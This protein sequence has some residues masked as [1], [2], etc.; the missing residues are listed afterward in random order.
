MLFINHTYNKD[1]YV[2]ER[3]EIWNILNNKLDFKGLAKKINFEIKR[4]S[5]L[6]IV[7]SPINFSGINNKSIIG[8]FK[9]GDSK[10]MI[11]NEWLNEMVERFTYLQWGLVEITLANKLYQETQ[12]NIQKYYFEINFQ[13]YSMYVISEIYSFWN[14]V[15]QY[16]NVLYMEEEEKDV[17]CGL[18]ESSE[19]KDNQNDFVQ[20]M[21]SEYM[22]AFNKDI[23]K[24][25]HHSTHRKRIEIT[26]LGPK[27]YTK[28]TKIMVELA[29]QYESIPAIALENKI[30]EVMN[31][32][33]KVMG[34][35]GDNLEM[36]IKNKG[37]SN[38]TI[39]RKN[40]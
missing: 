17:N 39:V 14:M 7:K 6:T 26:E 25:R 36:E 38:I 28:I 4:T 29:A 37:Y 12:D 22:N 30:I 31:S 35:C 33:I 15:A 34:Y 9:S 18:F 16:L 13:Y 19:I 3:E 32:I 10:I 21:R 40:N 1:N 20:N 8:S 5:E 27:Y 11:A 23:L 24:L 2:K